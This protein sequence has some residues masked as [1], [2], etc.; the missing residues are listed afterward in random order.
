[1]WLL[2]NWFRIIALLLLATIAIF[3]WLSCFG[4]TNNYKMD[5]DCAEIARTFIDKHNKE[6]CFNENL[7]QSRY[8]NYKKSCF[9][10]YSIFSA[11]TGISWNIYDLTHNKHIASLESFKTYGDATIYTSFAKEY[12]EVKSEIFGK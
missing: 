7:I 12:Q 8:S 6:G 11:V 1:M 2:R 9:V 3:V 10:E 5:S 4:N